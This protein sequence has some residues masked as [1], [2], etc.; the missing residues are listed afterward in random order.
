VPFILAR[1]VKTGQTV[2]RDGSMSTTAL[3]ELLGVEA[4]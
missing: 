2:T 3:A 4:P 1:N